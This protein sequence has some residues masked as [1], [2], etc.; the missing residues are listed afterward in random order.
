MV[1]LVQ[2]LEY[3]DDYKLRGDDPAYIR[4]QAIFHHEENAILW[5]AKVA[6]QQLNGAELPWDSLSPQ[7][8]VNL[9]MGWDVPE[10]HKNLYET[11]QQHTKGEYVPSRWQMFISDAKVE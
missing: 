8:I 7:D 10:K 2:I 11:I 6:K 9:V 1:W 3:V 4:K 5:A